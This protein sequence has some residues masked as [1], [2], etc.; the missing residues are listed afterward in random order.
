MVD[1]RIQVPRKFLS[2]QKIFTEITAI[3]SR[4]WNFGKN[5][6]YFVAKMKF[7]RKLP[8][9][10]VITPKKLK[11]SVNLTQDF[12]LPCRFFSFSYGKISRK[13]FCDDFFN[14][15]KLHFTENFLQVNKISFV[16]F[17]NFVFCILVDNFLFASARL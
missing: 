8:L 7:C 14:L 3:L 16:S 12:L 9:F 11:I 2:S 17:C 6:R 15:I 13:F 5:Y 1:L 4:K 10:Y